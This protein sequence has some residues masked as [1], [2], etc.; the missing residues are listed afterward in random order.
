[1]SETPHQPHRADSVVDAATEGYAAQRAPLDAQ[2]GRSIGEV[3]GDIT[4]KVSTLLRQEVDLA[5]AEVRDSGTKAG[6]GIGLLAGAGV[7]AVL[8]LVFISISAWWGLGQFIGNQWSALVVAAVWA[9]VAIILALAGKSAL[10]RIRG[11]PQTTETLRE[12]P[13]AMK[14][15]EEANR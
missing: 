14:G 1:M 15:N 2:D 4:E 8:L 10:K 6:K 7:A 12:I 5:K 11:V 3:M 9:I 13:N